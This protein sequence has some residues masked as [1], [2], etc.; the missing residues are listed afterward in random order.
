MPARKAPV[1]VARWTRWVA[2]SRRAYQS[3]SASIKRPSAS[4][5][6]TSTVRPAAVVITS[7]GRIALPLSMF[8]QAGTTP[9]TESGSPS[10]AVAPRAATTAPPPRPPRH[11]SLLT[12][13]VRLLLEEV[14][15][16]IERDGLPDERQARDADPTHL[17]HP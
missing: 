12:N 4:G 6:V 3:A 14:T 16:R 13:Y 11:V 1:R 8:S 17:T 5:F 10:S 7:V 2:P 9:V 15:P